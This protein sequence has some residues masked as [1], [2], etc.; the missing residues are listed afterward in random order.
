MM[1]EAGGRLHRFPG[2]NFVTGWPPLLP[3][4]DGE[5]EINDSHGDDERQ[6]DAVP[7]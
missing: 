1:S 7:V 5:S 3:P 6:T 4:P 2:V